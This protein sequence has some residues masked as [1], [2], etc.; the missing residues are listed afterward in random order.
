[1]SQSAPK[2]AW[3]GTSG[4]LH[5]GDFP[6]IYGAREPRKWFGDPFTVYLEALEAR[7]LDRPLEGVRLASPFLL[8]LVLHLMIAGRLHWRE[9]GARLASRHALAAFDF[10]DGTLIMTEAGAKKRASLHVLRGE[11]A[12]RTQDPGG[13]E[14]FEADLEAFR[15]ALLCE[16]HTLK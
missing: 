13:L 16:N 1:V 7:I 8:W 11:D 15:S 5:F 2:P 3:L 12:L 9:P 4:N 10:P 14:V 6:A